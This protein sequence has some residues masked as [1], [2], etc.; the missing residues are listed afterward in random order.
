[1]VQELKFPCFVA[2]VQFSQLMPVTWCLCTHN[3]DTDTKMTE[4]VVIFQLGARVICFL[5]P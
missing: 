4:K 2:A 5:R 3:E 1:M